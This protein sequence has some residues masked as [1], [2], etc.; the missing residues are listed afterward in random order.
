VKVTEKQYDVGVIIGRFQVPELHEAHLGLIQH[1][2]D[3]HDKVI[4]ILGLSPL[5][6]TINNPLDFESRKQMILA[7]FPRVSVLYVKDVNSDDIWSKKV[8]EIVGD[9][10]SPLQSAVLYGGR[11]S[12]IS[13]YNGR[14]ATRELEQDIFISGSEIR[15]RI[16]A[17]SVKAT[18]DFRAGMVYAS[19][20]VYANPKPTVDIAIFNEDGDKLLLG[21]KPT[22][23][24]F[25]F[26]G[27]F[28][29]SSDPSYEAAARREVSEETNIAI[30]D[31]IYVGSIQVDDW[32]YRGER[33][34]IMTTFFVARYQSGAVQPGDDIA[35]VRWF[36]IDTLTKRDIVDT[37]WPLLDRLLTHLS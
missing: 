21:R 24:A 6:G 7:S 37:H 32:R 17:S 27:G 34:K 4:V 19:Q 28:V 23:K 11:E 3:T 2:C 22:E 9:V 36:P 13:H 30:T 26:I 16:G 14:Y 15:K 31:P 10:L 1:V 12:F 18:S 33:D 8:D 20:S 5:R 35:E 25:R 29:D